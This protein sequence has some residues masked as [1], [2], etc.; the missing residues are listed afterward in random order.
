MAIAPLLHRAAQLAAAAEF[1]LFQSA[2]ESSKISK[3]IHG[4]TDRTMRPIGT[5]KP[6][7]LE[8][9]HK[10]DCC[11]FLY[12]SLAAAQIKVSKRVLILNQLEP[13]ASPGVAAMDQAITAV[14][15]K[16]PYQVQFFT[17]NLDANLPLS[18]AAQRALREWYVSR[19]LGR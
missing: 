11:C 15:E 7:P 2:P 19:Y 10:S 4:A 1:V 3:G 18:E 6:T 14:L 17:E 13:L 5:Q 16:S 8:S 9:P 12:P